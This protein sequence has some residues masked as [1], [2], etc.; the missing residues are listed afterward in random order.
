MEQFHDA[1]KLEPANETAKQGESESRDLLAKAL[2]EDLRR[3][4]NAQRI[5][6]TIGHAR[7]HDGIAHERFLPAGPFAILPLPDD[8][9]VHRSS[10][11]WTERTDAAPGYLALDGT[12]FLAEKPETA[13]ELRAKEAKR[14]E[15]KATKAGDGDQG[16]FSFDAE[17]D[18]S[19]EP[20]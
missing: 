8:R 2:A 11:V 6:A 18:P 10:L 1:N 7:P 3:T 15:R 16:N 19:D 13:A 14:R 17:A 9:G 20:E 12:R 4:Q 5:V